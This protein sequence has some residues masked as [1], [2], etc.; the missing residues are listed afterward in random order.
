MLVDL[1][2]SRLTKD[3]F[4]VLYP[5]LLHLPPFR[6]YTALEDAEIEVRVCAMF[7][8]TMGSISARDSRVINI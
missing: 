2:M 7:A 5:T 3:L 6:F 1:R 8:F 4:T